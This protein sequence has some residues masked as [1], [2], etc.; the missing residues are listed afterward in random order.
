MA[1]FSL[2][3]HA[4]RFER[5]YH[6]GKGGLQGSL[7]L[8]QSPALVGGWAPDVR[9][10]ARNLLYL[11]RERPF[12]ERRELLEMMGVALASVKP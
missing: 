3:T 2:A 5:E 10:V 12:E 4:A 11:A 9:L 1:H 8:A 6:R 7:P